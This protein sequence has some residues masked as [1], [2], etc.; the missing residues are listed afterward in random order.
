MGYKRYG[1]SDSIPKFNDDNN[2]EAVS[3]GILKNSSNKEIYF[4]IAKPKGSDNF[5]SLQN[6]DFSKGIQSNIVGC[7][8]TLTSIAN[9]LNIGQIRYNLSE[10]TTG[11]IRNI[12]FKYNNIDLFTIVQQKK[13]IRSE[14]Y[15][16]NCIYVKNISN[17][18]YAFLVNGNLSGQFTLS[19]NP[20]HNTCDGETSFV[21][22]MDTTESLPYNF[23][24]G[25][26]VD[27]L[28]QKYNYVSSSFYNGRIFFWNHTSISKYD[29]GSS[30]STVTLKLSDQFKLY[31]KSV[32]GYTFTIQSDNVYSFSKPDFT[33]TITVT[34]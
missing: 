15:T 18:L 10:N 28:K 29:G 2:G 32:N 16:L 7:T 20:L 30:F 5:R 1:S 8:A 9:K 17:P 4:G 26:N 3:N 31:K 6:S 34:S 24:G 33:A 11:V 25:A 22:C 13:I 27:T 21:V 19:G 12:T 23:S 14:T